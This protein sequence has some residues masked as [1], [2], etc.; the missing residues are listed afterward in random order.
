MSEIIL[1]PTLFNADFTDQDKTI[2]ELVIEQINPSYSVSGYHQAS[3]ITD[4]V[5]EDEVFSKNIHAP[6]FETQVQK[7]RRLS[8]KSDLVNP[9]AGN[10]DSYDELLSLADNLV[11]GV[12]SSEEELA[13]WLHDPKRFLSII[14]SYSW[15]TRIGLEDKSKDTAH[16]L[17]GDS[18]YFKTGETQ[19]TKVTWFN[20][21][22]AKTE[23]LDRGNLSRSQWA[24][25]RISRKLVD[26]PMMRI[27]SYDANMQ[28][29]VDMVNASGISINR[30]GSIV[31]I[32]ATVYPL[33][34]NAENKWA[35]PFVSIIEPSVLPNVAES[36]RLE[37]ARISTKGIGQKTATDAQTSEVVGQTIET[38]KQI[39][40]D[41]SL[42]AIP[43]GRMVTRGELKN[44][45]ETMA[46]S[47][48]L[49]IE[50]TTSAVAATYRRY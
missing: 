7:L 44:S 28:Q 16:P 18:L 33:A 27:L 40:P 25:Y 6:H 15:Q 9:F 2:S 41:N 8:R 12:S 1:K 23:D 10:E 37:R 49:D 47:S 4:L 48:F 22:G 13:D 42:L 29:E 11:N 36:S 45:L 32:A 17:S 3:R 46:P 26:N 30:N 19:A 50:K 43:M 14:L 24:R 31:P 5:Q 35:F 38:L 21:Y 34:K 39:T 20:R